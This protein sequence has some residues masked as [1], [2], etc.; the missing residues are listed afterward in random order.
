[1]IRS[2]NLLDVPWLLEQ[3]RE[4]DRFFG[5]KKK[6]F[7]EDAAIAEKT[8]EG[9]I[10]TQPFF[11][12][13]DTNGRT[14]FISGAVTQHPYNPE[15]LVLWEMFWW[16]VPEHRGSSAGARLLKH[17]IQYGIENEVD[18]IRMTLET[19]SPVNPASLERLGFKEFERGYLWENAA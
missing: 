14:G 11:I 18:W 6:L 8:L 13:A 10:T 7:P 15:L 4:F 17:F 2:A 3:L 9:L 16:V 5:A 1:V 12:A 19:G